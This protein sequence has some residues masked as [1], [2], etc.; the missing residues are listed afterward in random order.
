MQAATRERLLRGGIHLTDCRGAWHIK[1]FH[2][3]QGRLALA[4]R[5]AD[6]FPMPWR[7]AIE[8]MEKLWSFV[9]RAFVDEVYPARQ[10]QESCPNLSDDFRQAVHMLHVGMSSI[11]PCLPKAGGGLQC[12][13][14]APSNHASVIGGPPLFEQECER[15]GTAARTAEAHELG[16]IPFR[17]AY[18]S[19]SFRGEYIGRL[20]S[21]VHEVIK[22]RILSILRLWRSESR[23]TKRVLCVYRSHLKRITRNVGDLTLAREGMRAWRQCIADGPACEWY[24]IAADGVEQPLFSIDAARNLWLKLSPKDVEADDA[25]TLRDDGQCDLG[26]DPIG[27]VDSNVELE[28]E[29][30][31]RY[32]A[33]GEVGELAQGCFRVAGHRVCGIDSSTTEEEEVLEYLS[34]SDDAECDFEDD[35]LD[36]HDGEQ[37]PVMR[38]TSFVGAADV[39]E[40]PVSD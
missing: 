30:L 14:T 17:K 21:R 28:Q 26:V 12:A 24:V 2:G 10:Y 1:Q 32:L 19:M 29:E 9:I 7:G 8:H 27:T 6:L 5:I 33:E 25:E 3:N 4:V 36:E 35:G 16:H 11:F 23:L 22:H 38:E 15:G 13:F 34:P 31:E 40:I 37:L 39:H 20:S 18:W